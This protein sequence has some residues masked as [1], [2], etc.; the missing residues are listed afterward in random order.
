ME[1]EKRQP[2]SFLDLRIKNLRW[3]F[4][5]RYG[6]MLPEDDDGFDS[7]VIMINHLAMLPGPEKRIRNWLLSWA[8]WFTGPEAEKAIA[9]ALKSPTRWGA[10]AL[11]K[12][13]NLTDAERT[14]LK[15]WT[16]GAVDVTKEERE[17]RRRERDRLAKEAKRRAAGAKPQAESDRRTQPWKVLGI[18]ESTWRRRRRRTGLGTGDRH[19]LLPT[20]TG[21][22]IGEPNQEAT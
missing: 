18:S 14:R 22:A 8:P 6:C 5:A 11:A 21:H 2:P 13:M 19:D 16:I 7:A 3:L 4:R 9:R 12:R 10:D 1:H 20:K 15:T 17:R